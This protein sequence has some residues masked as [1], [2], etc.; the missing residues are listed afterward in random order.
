MRSRFKSVDIR[1][2]KSE[3]QACS[4]LAPVPY[5]GPWL[6]RRMV[7]RRY[8]QSKRLRRPIP[9]R[10]RATTYCNPLNLDYTYKITES[11]KDISYRSGADPAVVSFR[12]DYYMF[13]TRALG[14]WYSK[15]LTDGISSR[16]SAGTFRDPTRPPPRTIGIRLLYVTGDPSGTMSLLYTDDPQKGDWQAVP[17]L[18]RNLQDPDF[19]IDDDGRAL[20]V[21]GILEPLAD[22]RRGA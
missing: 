6:G 2:G 9:V 5:H 22:S 21:L 15:D 10:H 13:V 20:H 12:G 18:L 17:A 3:T 7:L 16:R 19:F 14:Y 11:D 1:G 4:T 8:K